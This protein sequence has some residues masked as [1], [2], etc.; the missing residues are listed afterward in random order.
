[1][2]SEGGTFFSVNDIAQ[3][4]SDIIPSKGGSIFSDGGLVPYEVV[5]FTG[6]FNI[7]SRGRYHALRGWQGGVFQEHGICFGGGVIHLL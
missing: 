1:M 4:E 3:F 6:R 7:F 2:F 5:I